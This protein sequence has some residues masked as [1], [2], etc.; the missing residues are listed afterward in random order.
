MDSK[1]DEKGIQKRIQK[2]M[3]KGIQKVYGANKIIHVTNRDFKIQ[4]FWI[5]E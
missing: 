3:Q 4:K 1:G 2:E 5:Y